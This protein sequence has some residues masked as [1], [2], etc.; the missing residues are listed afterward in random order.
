MVN[1]QNMA[2]TRD[3]TRTFIAA[4]ATH[5]ILNL[6]YPYPDGIAH[7]LDEEIIQPLKREFEG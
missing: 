5:L 3:N 7:R 2:A 1:P 4:G 6:R